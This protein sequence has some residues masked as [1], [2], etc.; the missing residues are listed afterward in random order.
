[1]GIAAHKA[2]AK[3][4]VMTS[5]VYGPIIKAGGPQVVGARDFSTVR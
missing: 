1:V 5:E 3:S 4:G 2:G